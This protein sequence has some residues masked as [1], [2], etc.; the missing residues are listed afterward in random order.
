MR[1]LIFGGTTEGRCLAAALANAGVDVTLS[2]AT[3]FCREALS[4]ASGADG[5]DMMILAERLEEKSIVDLLQQGSFAYVIDATHPYAVLATQNIRLACQNAGQ[6]YIRLKRPESAKI[7]GITYVAD[8]AAALEIVKNNDEK[9]LLT[10][11]SKELALFTQAKN[12]AQRFFIRILPMQDSLHKALELGFRGSNIICM[13]G[14]FDAEMNLATL[15]MTGA[16]YL[17]TKDSGEM[18]GFEAKVAAA[19][20]LGCEVIVIDRPIR[21]EGYTLEELLQFF[22]IK[23]APDKSPL[24]TKFFP[25]FFDIA[26]KRILV[27]GGGKVAERRI[28]VLSAFAAQIT[29]ISPQVSEYLACAAAK[30]AIQWLARAYRSGDIGSL[31]PFLV[32]AATADRQANQAAMKEANSLT[33]PVAVADCREECTCYF[34]ALAESDSYIAGIVSKN[35]D[36]SGVKRMAEKVRR[37]LDT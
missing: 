37:L 25:L 12:Y 31:Q 20:S 5:K 32:V 28:K 18:G 11:G 36:H 1:V 33:I 16:K 4:V 14:P 13:Q 2:V 19:L 17:L 3:G 29:V 30:G 22:N 6:K 23:E 35:G 9:V 8:E 15:K 7:S 21:E 27:L 24:N 10:I 26:A 34:P